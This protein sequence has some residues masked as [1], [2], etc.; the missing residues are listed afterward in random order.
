MQSTKSRIASPQV[1]PDVR[2]QQDQRK[3]EFGRRLQQLCLQRG[4][5]QSELARR[6][7]GEHGEPMGR[8]AISTYIRG[9]SWPEPVNLQRLARAFDISVEDLLG[10][11]APA[12]SEAPP[13]LEIRQ[14]AGNPDQ[15]W[16]RINRMVTAEQA[17]QIFNI[18][19]EAK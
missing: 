11:V 12:G 7:K 4:W 1:I 8:D 13:I 18:I 5:T 14:A 9:R 16:I 15:V 2:G 6:A 17:A 19:R 10:G 3:L